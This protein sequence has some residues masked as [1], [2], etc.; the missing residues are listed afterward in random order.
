LGA[1]KKG[2]AITD[3]ELSRNS[4]KAILKACNVKVGF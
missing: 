2:G 3:N 1:N 4:I